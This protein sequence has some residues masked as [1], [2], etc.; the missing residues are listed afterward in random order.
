M[1]VNLWRASKRTQKPGKKTTTQTYFSSKFDKTSWFLDIATSFRRSMFEERL[2]TCNYFRTSC[3]STRNSCNK[4]WHDTSNDFSGYS[5]VR[6]EIQIFIG[7]VKHYHTLFIFFGVQGADV[8]LEWSSRSRWL[9]WLILPV[10]WSPRW[11]NCAKSWRHSSG[12][13]STR[14]TCGKGKNL[15]KSNFSI[16]NI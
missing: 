6:I 3:A 16:L 10:R 8:F 2:S 4:L 9:F 11:T 5:V 13:S 14:M 1:S 12:I 7:S 15:R